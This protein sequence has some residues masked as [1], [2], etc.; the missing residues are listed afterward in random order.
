MEPGETAE[1]RSETVSPVD[2]AKAELVALVDGLGSDSLDP[3]RASVERLA[4]WRA[5]VDAA[6]T[7]KVSR[8]RSRVQAAGGTV[9][10]LGRSGG[11][12]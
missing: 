8:H 4:Q 6:E 1:E 5:L 12:E 11:F 9:R 10:V 3:V 2:T 7:A